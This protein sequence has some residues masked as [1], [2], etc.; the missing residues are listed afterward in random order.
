MEVGTV[1][2]LIRERGYGF[3][4]RFENDDLFFHR[5]ALKHISMDEIEEGERVEFEVEQGPKG[6]RATNVR[7]TV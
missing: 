6:L 5:S 7:L 3:I 4:A 2:R 1:T